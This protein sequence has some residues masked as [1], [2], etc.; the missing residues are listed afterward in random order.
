TNRPLRWTSTS[1][2]IAEKLELLHRHALPC[3]RIRCEATLAGRADECKPTAFHPR[4]HATRRFRC[5]MH[6]ENFPQRAGR[7]FERPWGHVALA[8]GVEAAK[9]RGLGGA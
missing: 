3:G 5:A 9:S 1:R 8:D 6:L 7:I 4:G 2:R